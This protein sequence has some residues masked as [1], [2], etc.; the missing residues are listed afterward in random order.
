MPIF[1]YR[2]LTKDGR[3]TKGVVDSDNLRAARARLKKDGIFVVD[4]KDKKKQDTSKLKSKT[5]A[6]KTVSVKDISLMTRQLAT[7]IKANIPLVDAL[8]AISEQVDNP[9]L[10]ESLADCKNMVGVL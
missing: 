6:T 2:G 9:V 4:I 1:E 7:L 5:V 3:N 8:G 10:A